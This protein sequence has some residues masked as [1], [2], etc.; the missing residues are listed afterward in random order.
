MCFFKKKIGNK[1]ACIFYD[2]NSCCSWFCLKIANPEIFTPF[3]IEL[4]LQTSVVGFNSMLSEKLLKEYS[5]SKN[6]NFFMNLF[7][8]LIY[9]SIYIIFIRGIKFLLAINNSKKYNCC[10]KFC[11]DVFFL[12]YFLFFFSFQAFFYSKEYI[13]TDFYTGDLLDNLLSNMITLFKSLDF[14]MLSYYDFFDDSDCLNTAVVITF[15][16]FFWMIIEV[17]LDSTEISTKTLFIIQLVCSIIFL[18]L[19]ILI[20]IN[21]IIDMICSLINNEDK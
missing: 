6:R 12:S 15:E 16:K 19:T 2:Y 10:Y 7:T 21:L 8:C 20:I 18:I 9:I 17:V 13:S 3:V 11:N 1:N 5:F 4:F 14:Q